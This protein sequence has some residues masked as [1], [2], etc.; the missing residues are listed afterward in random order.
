[1]I[2]SCDHSIFQTGPLMF[3]P[4]TGNLVLLLVIFVTGLESKTYQCEYVC[5]TILYFC[6]IHQGIR[7][8][9]QAL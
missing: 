2:N 6:E 7:Q 4:V 5:C 8:N 1:M 9:M 3:S